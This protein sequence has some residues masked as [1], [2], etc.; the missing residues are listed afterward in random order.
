MCGW[1]PIQRELEVKDRWGQQEDII[2]KEQW[3]DSE[4]TKPDPSTQWL[5]LEILS[6][7]VIN[8]IGDSLTLTGNQ[9]DLLPA[10][11]APVLQGAEDLYRAEEL[12]PL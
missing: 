10:L 9:F 8:K 6:T 3:R 2:C 11:R 12:I 1:K 7:I 5:R 4:V